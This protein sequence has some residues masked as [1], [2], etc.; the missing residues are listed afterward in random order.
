MKFYISILIFLLTQIVKSSLIAC[1]EYQCADSMTCCEGGCA[2]HIR[3]DANFS[4]NFDY[5]FIDN[6]HWNLSPLDINSGS[7]QRIRCGYDNTI[8]QTAYCGFVYTGLDNCKIKFEVH[9]DTNG[10]IIDEILGNNMCVGVL[11]NCP[12]VK[13][14][15]SMDT[16][17]MFLRIVNHDGCPNGCS[18]ITFYNYATPYF[19]EVV[20]FVEGQLDTVISSEVFQQ[21]AEDLPEIIASIFL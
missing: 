9:Q 14:A 20:D 21:L 18:V 3:N 10:D 4:L 8:F 16:N 7:F 6:S 12:G 2:V 17:P 19:S 13:I 1:S 15:L 11:N 5:D